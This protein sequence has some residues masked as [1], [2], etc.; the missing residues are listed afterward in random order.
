VI[1]DEKEN[2]KIQIK[3]FKTAINQTTKIIQVPFQQ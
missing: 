2:F 1:L 3:F